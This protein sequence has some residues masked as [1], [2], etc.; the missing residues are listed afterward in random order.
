MAAL[1]AENIATSIHFIPVHTLT[2]Y[3]AHFP[4]QEPLPEAERAGEQLL[5]LPLSPAHSEGDIADAVDALHR[6][7]TRF[8]A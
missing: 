3:R 8:T 2:W 1:A 4:G 5:S 6:V 7:H